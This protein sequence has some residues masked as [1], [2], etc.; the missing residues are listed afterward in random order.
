[1]GFTWLL[2]LS[3]H[4]GSVSSTATGT[5]L[6]RGF[7][8][9]TGLLYILA[10]GLHR[11]A[12]RLAIPSALPILALALVVNWLHHGLHVVSHGQVETLHTTSLALLLFYAGLN[13]DLDRIRGRLSLAL[14][15][16]TIG[17]LLSGLL[18][19]LLLWAL[20]HIGLPF[21]PRAGL[22][23]PLPLGV[24]MLTATC[25]LPTDG[26]ANEE[27]DHQWG[28]H[29]PK[30]VQPVLAFEAALGSATAILCF[31]LVVT[32]F[33]AFQH[34]GQGDFRF[35]AL[36][37]LPS[38]LLELVRHLLAGLAAGLLVG[39]L[40]NR[41]I[42]LLVSHSEH[43]LILAVSVAFV[44]YA[45]GN[46]LGGGGLISVYIAGLVLAN[47]PQTRGP[48]GHAGLRHVL[49]PFNTTAEF[50]ML[51]LLGLLVH[52]GVMVQMLPLGMVLGLLLELLVRPLVVLGLGGAPRGQRLERLLIAAGGLRGAVPLALSLALL[53]QVPRLRDVHPLEAVDLATQ[54]QALVAVAVITSL[55]LKGVVLPRLLQRWVSPESPPAEAA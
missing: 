42:P 26:S 4:A 37:E 16:P 23:A 38:S 17:I 46:L 53:E 6:P 7:F 20:G 36:Q 12:C 29:A 49:L 34:G 8:L 10:L 18:L 3:E 15:L 51:L 19:G 27:L 21:L 22:A 45:M 5:I 11:L 39:L 54:M 32:L 30:N 47:R 48:F 44:A 35:G 40:A 9:A 33:L 24:A 13:T 50:T 2:T 41:L 25:L 14:T 52:P 31:G 28:H 55:V 1:M 43:L